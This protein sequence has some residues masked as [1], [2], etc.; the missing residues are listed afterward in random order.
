MVS[1]P[2][3]GRGRDWRGITGTGEYGGMGWRV[4]ALDGKAG[5]TTTIRS[6]RLLVPGGGACD[7][8]RRTGESGYHRR[9]YETTTGDAG[10]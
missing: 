1:A 9:V 10:M 8:R 3:A 4:Y 7:R 5:A 2:R 6:N